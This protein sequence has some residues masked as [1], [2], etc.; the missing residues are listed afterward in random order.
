MQIDDNEV[1]LWKATDAALTITEIAVTLNTGA[2]EVAGDLK[3]ADAFIGLANPV[4]INAFDT[5][6]G[7]LV[8][9]SITNAAVPSGKCLYL[10]FD[11][12]PDADITQMNIV[13]I[14]QYD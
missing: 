5:V 10:S 8:D 14:F 2:E 3:Y 11:S 1:C 13:I 6:S 12:A 9:T 4:V 7:V